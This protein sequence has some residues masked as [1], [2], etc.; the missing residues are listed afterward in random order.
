MNRFLQ[1]YGAHYRALFTLGMP[2]VVGQLGVIILGF[3]DTLMVGHHS[4]VE[5]GAASFVNNMFNLCIIFW[6]PTRWW[7]CWRWR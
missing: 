4:T 1:T 7:P 6:W 2:I 5:L 3:A